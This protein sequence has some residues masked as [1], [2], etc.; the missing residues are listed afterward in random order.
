[1]KWRAGDYERDRESGLL[2]PRQSRG[3][4]L[5][6]AH[7]EFM[8][9]GPAFYGGAAGGGG[10]DPDFSSVALL[11]HF[12]GS[13]A[14]SSSYNHTPS[15]TGSG[16]T[17]G[18]GI[19]RF[20]SGSLSGFSSSNGLT[21]ASHASFA[22][23]GAFTM[24]CWIRLTTAPTGSNCTIWNVG[25]FSSGMFLR[26]NTLS[27]FV[28]YF[29]NNPQFFTGSALSTLTWYFLQW[30]RDASDN[31][32]LRIDGTQYGLAHSAAASIAAAT[33][34]IGQS[35]HNS[36]EFFTGNIDELRYTPGIVR[37]AT[38]PTTAFPNS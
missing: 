23:P 15:T 12:D 37:P 13:F 38:V 8:G 22:A 24:E 32:L 1:M 30:I 16:L 3:R 31:T 33:V 11:P 7:P 6:Q 28:F 14:D 36:G 25:S 27:E 17:T 26:M 4:G 20:G 5:A 35:A 9:A 2:L 18:S 29:N 21:Y 19:A 10:G 34:R